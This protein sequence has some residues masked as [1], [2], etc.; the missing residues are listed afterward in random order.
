MSLTQIFFRKSEHTRTPQD[1]TFTILATI[2]LKII[3]FTEISKFIV[4]FKNKMQLM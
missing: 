1:I 4:A 2:S 3:T